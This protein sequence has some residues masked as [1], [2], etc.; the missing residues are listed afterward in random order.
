MGPVVGR[1]KFTGPIRTVITV[2]QYLCNIGHSWGWDLGF[3]HVVGIL[4]HCSHIIVQY[5]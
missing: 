3:L 2:C 1:G 5:P 4:P